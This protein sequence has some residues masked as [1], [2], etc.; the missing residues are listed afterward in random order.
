MS[1]IVQKP[2]HMTSLRKHVNIFVVMLPSE[3]LSVTFTTLDFTLADV[4]L[5]KTNTLGARFM[6]FNQNVPGFQKAL[7]LQKK[8]PFSQFL[9]FTLKAMNTLSPK[10]I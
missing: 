3:H 4:L 10:S 2:N 1:K 5:Q 7:A 8:K 6:K 9:V